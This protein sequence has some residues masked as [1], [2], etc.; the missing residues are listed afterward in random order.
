[1]STAFTG[2]K[3]NDCATLS[4]WLLGTTL[5]YHFQTRET[6]HAKIT[7]HIPV[8]HMLLSKKMK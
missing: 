6:A 1:M 8:W 3:F 5:A 7:F 4:L 2:Q